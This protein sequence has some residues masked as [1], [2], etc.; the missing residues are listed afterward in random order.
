[1]IQNLE[2]KELLERLSE[3]DSERAYKS[4]FLLLF[5]RLLEFSNAIVKSREDAEEVVSDFFIKVW[6]KRN[7]LSVIENPKLYCFVSVKNLSINRLIANKKNFAPQVA[8]NWDTKLTN[9]FFNPEELMI[10]KEAVAKIM[11]LVNQLPP[12]CKTIFKM[13]KEEGLKYKDVAKLL[14]ISPKTVEAQMAIALR[15]IKQCTDFKSEFPVLHSIL[16][17]PKV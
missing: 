8:D 4:L 9:A 7:S 10:S 13:V 3:E 15:R 5:P 2:I 6:Q 1:M 11:T 14:D 12:K 16:S 17:K